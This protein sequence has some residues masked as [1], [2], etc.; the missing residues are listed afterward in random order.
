MNATKGFKWIFIVTFL[1]VFQSFG[2][3]KVFE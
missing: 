3:Q 2:Q 1:S